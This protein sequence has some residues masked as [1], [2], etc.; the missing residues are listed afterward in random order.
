MT[1]STPAL[2]DIK[3][4]LERL[5]DSDR[6]IVVALKGGWGEGKTFF[7][8]ESIQKHRSKVSYVSLFGAAS[9]LEIRERVLLA[10]MPLPSSGSDKGRFRPVVDF[11]QTAGSYIN[12]IAKGFGVSLPTS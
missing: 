8:R 10:S 7:W 2:A 9:I 4:S 6:P 11:L 3:T 1:V 5:L 12:S